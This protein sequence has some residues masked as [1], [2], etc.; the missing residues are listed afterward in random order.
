MPYRLLT[1]V[2]TGCTVML[3]V[4]LAS[5]VFAKEEWTVCNYKVEAV[6]IDSTA[7]TLTVRLLQA[8]GGNP[9]DCP[10]ALGDMTFRPETKDYQSE[11]ARKQWPRPGQR[12]LLRFRY[13][14]GNC[15]YAGPCR[16]HHYSVSNK[17]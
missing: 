3:T 16:I 17:F 14:D 8:I 9:H 7:R 5:P 12:S 15:K 11:L 4:T 2:I 1:K 10:A 13:L 6:R